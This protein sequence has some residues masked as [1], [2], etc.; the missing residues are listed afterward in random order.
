MEKSGAFVAPGAKM[1]LS[2]GQDVGN[3]QRAHPTPGV[4]LC[5]TMPSR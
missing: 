1:T 2:I 3:T 4:G 5:S